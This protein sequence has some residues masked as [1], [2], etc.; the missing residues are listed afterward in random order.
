MD[1]LKQNILNI[2]GIQGKKWLSDLPSVI[3]SLKTSWKLHDIT[4]VKNMTFNY[5]AKAITT[6]GQPVILKIG[7]DPKSIENEKQA[8][9]YFNGNGSIKLID[10]AEK[11]HALLLQQAISGITLTSFYPHQIDLVI[12]CYTSTMKKLHSKHL[13]SKYNYPHISEWL[14][15]IDKLT[16][17]H[18]I[19]ASLLTN[20]ISLKNKLLKTIATEVFLHGDLHHDNILK[21]NNE[22]LAIDPKGVIGETA[23]EIAAFDFMY[24]NELANDINVNNTVETRINLLAKKAD[25]DAQRIKDWI[26]VRLVLMAAWN[27]EDNLNPDNAIKLAATLIQQQKRL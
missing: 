9:I 10:H 25:L 5:V 24:L 14:Q 17:N 23:F 4:P 18:H 16:P 26:L 2:Y 13:P 15:A 7:Y 6:T 11:Y 21:H 1:Q 12:D 19:P 8:L 20:V 22:W 3:K 27:I